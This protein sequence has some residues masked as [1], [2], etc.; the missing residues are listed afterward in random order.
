[1]GQNNS[2]GKNTWPKRPSKHN[3][4][5]SSLHPK[6]ILV[7]IPGHQTIT[8]RRWQHRSNFKRY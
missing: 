6:Q 1:M 2:Y 8:Y 3:E 5:I 4:Q 7:R